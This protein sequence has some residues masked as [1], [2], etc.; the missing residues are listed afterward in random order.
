MVQV[1]PDAVEAGSLMMDS[2][3]TGKTYSTSFV[4]VRTISTVFKAIF[5]LSNNAMTTLVPATIGNIS[6][7]AVILTARAGVCT[8]VREN[9]LYRDLIAIAIWS[10]ICGFIAIGNPNMAGP[11]IAFF[12]VVVLLII[13]LTM[14]DFR[15]VKRQH[16]EGMLGNQSRSTGVPTVVAKA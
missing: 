2:A 8:D 7:L 16:D 4:A 11:P 9:V 12:L 14:F 6:V 10:N 1:E 3:F 5:S 13:P 15:P